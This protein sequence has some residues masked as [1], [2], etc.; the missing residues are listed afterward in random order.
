[1]P[2]QCQLQLQLNP[3]Q[4]KGDHYETNQNET[5]N[6]KDV[7]MLKRPKSGLHSSTPAPLCSPLS[8]EMLS[9]NQALWWSP[10]GKHV[11]YAEFNDTGVHNIEYSWYGNEQYPTTVVIPYPKVSPAKLFLL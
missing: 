8:E 10:G 7:Q 6:C 9:S 11:A 5:L 2:S 3:T 1:M 4:K